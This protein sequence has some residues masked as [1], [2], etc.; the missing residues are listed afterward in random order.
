MT[1]LGRRLLLVLLILCT[2]CTSLFFHPY[3]ERYLT[4]DQVGLTYK[5]LSITNDQ[6]EKLYGWRLTT[7]EPP[8]TLLIFLHG[9][10]GNI[11]TH[12]GTIAHFPKEG[13]EV[14][15]MDYSGYGN[16][17]GI[18]SIDQIHSDVEEMIRVFSEE[19]KSRDLPFLLIGESL[20]ATLSLTV[21]S[22]I[23]SHLRPKC[24]GA[25]A[26]FSSYRSI[27]REKLATLWLTYLFQWPLGFLVTDT[28][29]PI[30]RLQ[31]YTIPT[32]LIHGSSDEVV[33]YHHSRDLCEK[34]GTTC[35]QLYTHNG[36]HDGTML[37]LD[38]RAVVISFLK[39][40]TCRR[41]I[42]SQPET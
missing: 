14:V 18:A 35:I 22:A 9:N 30:D 37:Q 3:Q 16:S 28:F 34:M 41:K 5:E 10:A 27:A 8:H 19:A 12:L 42:V 25:I 4:P 36:G 6:G 7:V 31:E 33:P 13:F 20:G 11:S 15:T 24:I 17:G 1:L 2:G 39:S 21:G 32:L 40:S 38:T 23:P 26:P 29:S